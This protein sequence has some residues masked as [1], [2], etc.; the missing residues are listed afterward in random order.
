MSKFNRHLIVDL[1]SYAF[2]RDT[3]KNRLANSSHLNH[4]LRQQDPLLNQNQ[5]NQPANPLKEVT[6]LV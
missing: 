5:K 1:R 3:S 6:N 2:R 4:R